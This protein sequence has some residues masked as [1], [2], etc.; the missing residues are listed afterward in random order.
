MEKIRIDK[1]VI[2]EGKYDKIKLE[3][4]I[5][6]NIIT[7][8]GFSIF[9]NEEKIALL[10]RIAQKSGIIILTDSDGAGF[11]LRNKLRGMLPKG[12]NIIHLYIPAQEGKEKR[13]REPSKAGLLGVE[14]ID[15][16]VLRNI[17]EKYKSMDNTAKKGN[18]ITKAYL[19]E[20]GLSGKAESSRRRNA[21]AKA[22]GLPEGM[23]ANAFLEAMSILGI[24][25]E[26]LESTLCDI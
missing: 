20:L 15:A 6:A 21:S 17:F 9:N 18:S 1:T 7:T 8:S 13:K 25:K 11:V 23:S 22:L 24:E 10:R 4:I 3:S 2:V 19:Y 5:D 14:G 26:E 16:D 12:E